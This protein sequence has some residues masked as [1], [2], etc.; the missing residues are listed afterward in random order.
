MKRSTRIGVAAALAAVAAALAGTAA[1]ALTP[2]VAVTG[3]RLGADQAFGPTFSIS[4][5]AT[6]DPVAR[7]TIYV[8]LDYTLASP[9]SPS[10][11]IGN[12]T[13]TA[14]IADAGNAAQTVKGSIVG[15]PP[16]NV[17]AACDPGTHAAT[18]SMNL[19]VPG[20]GTAVQ[21]PMYVDQA[22]GSDA[23]FASYKVVVCLPPPDVPAGTAGRSALGAR[24]VSATFN[25]DN[26]TGGGNGDEVWRALL[27]PYAPGAGQANADG[28]V[29][30]QS[31]VRV[32]TVVTLSAKRVKGKKATTVTLRGAVR[33]TG[34][35]IGGVAVTIGSGKSATKLKR[36][37]AVRTAA[38][39]TFST[40]AS[41]TK[42]TWFG[43]TAQVPQ[44]TLAATFC[45]PTFG[46]PCVSATVGASRVV[47]KAIK[48]AR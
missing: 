6:D 28:A 3:S 1:A 39:G 34:N 22:T 9:A 17:S 30:A 26:F 27:V 19:T 5:A 25:L 29:E 14:R 41:I 47:G 33:E 18:W 32:P 24:L 48:V 45:K 12:V 21:I 11:T 16:A 10:S 40:R 8:P 7:L 2:T 4:T 31:I 13:A 38:N 46:L 42:A 36:L 35:A 20:A 37:R 44:R 23:A 15:T 43:A